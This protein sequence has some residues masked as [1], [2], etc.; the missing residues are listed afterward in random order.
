M[1]DAK[2]VYLVRG[3]DNLWSGDVY[4][5]GIF[6]T[7]EKAQLHIDSISEEKKYDYSYVV[8]PYTLDGN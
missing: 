1:E 8:Y 4:I 5:E 7:P 3:H 2:V 6:S